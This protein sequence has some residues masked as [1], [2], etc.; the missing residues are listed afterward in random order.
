MVYT[1]STQ[2]IEHVYNWSA[3]FSP[4]K[5]YV[6]GTPMSPTS[7]SQHQR[8]A[9]EADDA[10]LAA[11]IAA[12][13]AEAQAMSPTVSTGPSGAAS[14]W[15]TPAHLAHAVP[16]TQPVVHAAQA[17]TP[18]S[19][20]LPATQPV[21]HAGHAVQAV[22]APV[23]HAVTAPAMPVPVQPAVALASP[24]VPP[25][26]VPEHGPI[27]G[28][29]EGL[30]YKAPPPSANMPGMGLVTVDP[31][32]GQLVKAPPP[33]AIS[34]RMHTEQHHQRT[35]DARGV[36]TDRHM[37]VHTVM[38]EHGTVP[39]DDYVQSKPMPQS[40]PYKAAPSGAKPPP[41]TSSGS[42]GPATKAPPQ[43]LMYASMSAGIII[44]TGPA[45]AQAAPAHAALPRHSRQH[46]VDSAPP[47]KAAPLPVHAPEPAAEPVPHGPPMTFRPHEGTAADAYRPPATAGYA[48]PQ[49][50]PWTESHQWK[51]A[52][53]DN[54][55]LLPPDA[56]PFKPRWD[57]AP[58]DKFGQSPSDHVVDMKQW[59]ICANKD[60][61]A[62]YTGYK[63]FL[64][65][66]PVDCTKEELARWIV[67]T[68][69]QGERLMTRAVCTDINVSQGAPSGACQAFFTFVTEED[70]TELLLLLSHWWQQCPPLHFNQYRRWRWLT[71]RQCIPGYFWPRA[72]DWGPRQ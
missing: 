1:W 16:A 68:V 2:G 49:C 40:T 35:V 10:L 20:A 46:I 3:Q 30:P 26:T 71:V 60:G 48:L 41:L 15:Q 55:P 14:S 63:V 24:A 59:Q 45:A 11:A 52:Y 64:G 12:S 57:N 34:G 19:P 58:K 29:S 67:A 62:A 44:G 6:C 47:P 27:A 21:V 43:A 70:A 17:V 39:E 54:L 61:I 65:D 5:A 36:T 42:T 31:R 66:L 37:T 56:P 50:S 9:Q 7:T 22:T 18:V 25:H 13:E 72:D 51:Q 53:D 23:A 69:P 33:C 8:E 4:P 28:V 32:S 38:I